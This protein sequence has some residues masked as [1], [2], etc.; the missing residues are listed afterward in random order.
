[1]ESRPRLKDPASERIPQYGHVV[2]CHPG[3]DRILFAFPGF[4]PVPPPPFTVHDGTGGVNHRLVLDSCRVI[5]N[6]Q[7]GYL[8]TDIGG[9][10]RVLATT[11]TLPCG[12]YYLH[13]ANPLTRT[14]YKIVADFAAWKFPLSLPA[15]WQRCL[16]RDDRSQLQYFMTVSPSSMSDAVKNADAKCVVSGYEHSLQTAHLLPEEEHAWFDMWRMVNYCLNDKAGINDTANGVALGSDIYLCLD[17]GGFVFYP[18]EPHDHILYFVIS[19][20]DYAQLL[21]RRPVTIHKRVSDAFLY[22]R[23]AYNII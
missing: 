6:N 14:C 1:M 11:I 9:A 7:D 17:R 22:A 3:L 2:I 4:D 20:V 10:K 8:K 19:E 15:H 5:T 18:C 16:S 23:F 13:L 21:H 12:V